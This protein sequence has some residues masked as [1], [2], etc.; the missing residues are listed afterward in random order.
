MKCVVS[1]PGGKSY[2]FIFAGE[3]LG[4][5]CLDKV[6]LF[7]WHSKTFGSLTYGSYIFV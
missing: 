1:E 7:C 5:H 2:E 6:N 4:Q 3:T